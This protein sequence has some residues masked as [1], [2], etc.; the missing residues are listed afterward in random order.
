ME[1]IATLMALKSRG[2]S[3]KSGDPDAGATA[4]A[5]VI[6]GKKIAVVPILGP[7]W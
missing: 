6:A 3:W 5:K 2:F 4:K 1:E 7:A